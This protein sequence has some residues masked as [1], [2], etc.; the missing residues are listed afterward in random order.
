M[1]SKTGEQLRRLCNAYGART[2][3][4]GAGH[5]QS[6]PTAAMEP[7]RDCSGQCRGASIPSA[8]CG[9]RIEPRMGFPSARRG[10]GAREP[11]RAASIHHLDR[12]LGPPPAAGAAVPSARKCRCGGTIGRRCCAS[13]LSWTT[14]GRRSCRCSWRC[15]L[16]ETNDR[17]TQRQYKRSQNCESIRNGSISHTKPPERNA[18]VY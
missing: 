15:G 18:R 2:G 17:Q 14:T 6:V 4:S 12:R 13:T 10:V 7:H 1:E 9:S 16:A 8:G 11:R 5:R 3:R